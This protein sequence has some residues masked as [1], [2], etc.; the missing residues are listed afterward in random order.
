[1][2]ILIISS[3]PKHKLFGS[4]PHELFEGLR[5][6]GH[7]VKLVVK[8]YYQH[9]ASDIVSLQGPYDDLLRR[10]KAK[11]VRSIGQFAPLLPRTDGNF[12]VQDYKEEINHFSTNEILKKADVTPDAIIYIF[13]GGLLNAK[14]IFELNKATGAPVYWYLMDSAALTGG[15][16]YSWDCMGYTRGCGC[17]PALYSN[18]PNDQSALNFRFK[19]NYFAQSD[20]RIVCGSSWQ[21]RMA[22][23]SPLFRAERIHKILLSF[24]PETFHPGSKL[25][26]RRILGLPPEAPILFFGATA[27]GEKRKGM[28]YLV[29]ALQTYKASGAAGSEN[30]RLLVAGSGFPSIERD[31][32]YPTRHLGLLSS[33]AELATAFQASD[34]FAC[35][36]IEDAGPMMINQAIMCGR[37]VLAFEMGVAEDLVHRG[38]TGYRAQ[39]KDSDDLAC[40]LDELLSMNRDTRSYYEQHCRDLALRKYSPQVHINAWE[41]LLHQ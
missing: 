2:T 36:S 5:S 27:L 38:T 3:A 21:Y 16:H 20:I 25:S 33:D 7:R 37:P 9:K 14:N 26:A 35:P 4:I 34:C 41:A 28:R 18:D 24:S 19:K 39:L 30:L 22:I 31:L 40:G 6:K 10:A 17:C 23:K 1:M 12:N 32:P 15:C 13:P 8:P 29:R 11:L